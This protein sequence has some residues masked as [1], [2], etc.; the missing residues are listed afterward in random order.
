VQ[1]KTIP[2]TATRLANP[3]LG[4][5]IVSMGEVARRVRCGGRSL[6]LST[7]NRWRKPGLGGV[8][9]EA[10]RLGGRW[11]TSLEALDRFVTATTPSNLKPAP[12]PSP[13]SRR[14]ASV[15]RALE[16]EGL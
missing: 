7:V 4:E 11:V 12:A 14:R 9:L 8:C 1:N 2:T 3:I 16:A 13:S 15:A 10:V 5:T 6:H